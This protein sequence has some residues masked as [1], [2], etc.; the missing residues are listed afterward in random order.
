MAMGI[1]PIQLF[2]CQ[3]LFTYVFEVGVSCLDL[4]AIMTSSRMYG[5]VLTEYDHVDLTLV[6]SR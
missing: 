3:F 4:S 5:N 1:S 6:T 2:I